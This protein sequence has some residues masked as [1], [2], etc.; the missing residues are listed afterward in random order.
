MSINNSSCSSICGHGFLNVDI[1]TLLRIASIISDDDKSNYIIAAANDDIVKMLREKKIQLNRPLTVDDCQIEKVEPNESVDYININLDLYDQLEYED[2]DAI[3]VINYE[4]MLRPRNHIDERVAMAEV[5]TLMK[6]CNLTYR[7]ERIL[8][9]SYPSVLRHRNRTNRFI[10][11]EY[12]NI[13]VNANMNNDKPSLNYNSSY[14]HNSS[15][16]T[17]NRDRTNPINRNSTKINNSYTHN[18]ELEKL[19]QNPD[20]SII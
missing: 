14:N 18:S 3:L 6:A 1:K 11:S 9:D 19:K 20:L 8:Q 13:E 12:S 7:Y 10:V 5:D 2:K 17:F 16:I 15:K 4:N